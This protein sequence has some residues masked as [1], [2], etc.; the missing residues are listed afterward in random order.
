MG[1][2]MKLSTKQFKQ[3]ATLIATARTNQSIGRNATEH[4]INIFERGLV[5]LMK[6]SNPQFNE[7]V[8]VGFVGDEIDRLVN[9]EHTKKF[10]IMIQCFSDKTKPV[11]F[12]GYNKSGDY[13]LTQ[14]INDAKKWKQ[15]S[16]AEKNL[17]KLRQINSMGFTHG[18]V[19]EIS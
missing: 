19:D 16:V 13:T 14:R 18:I 3:L 17:T 4:T 10:V 8:F 15:Q 11:Y 2:V 5:E 1:C 9:G 6:Q 12:A 7:S